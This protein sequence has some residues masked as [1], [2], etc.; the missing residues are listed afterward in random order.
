MIGLRWSIAVVIASA[1]FVLGRLATYFWFGMTGRQWVGVVMAV[2]IGMMVFVPLSI[3]FHWFA[4]QR[5][6]ES[7]QASALYYA[8]F[9]PAIV[10]GLLVL[11]SLA[12]AAAVAVVS[13]RKLVSHSRILRVVAIWVAITLTVATTL[14]IL[15]PDPRATY[16]WCLG[17]TTLAVPLARVLVLPASLAWNRHR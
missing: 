14:A 8:G 12:V 10:I 13:S 2:V 3:A 9:L 4:Q 1:T 6:W 16:L 15:I 7:A 11:K 17:L 5:D